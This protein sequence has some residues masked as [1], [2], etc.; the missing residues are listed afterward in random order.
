MKHI[1]TLCAVALCLFVHAFAWAGE[2]QIE[3][4]TAPSK[5]IKE[6]LGEHWFLSGEAKLFVEVSEGSNIVYRTKGQ[7]I[8]GEK[9]LYYFNEKFS[10]DANTLLLSVKVAR[11]EGNE[12]AFHA[13]VG[14]GG[15]AAA[16]AAVGATI[17]GVATGGLLA[18]AGA[19][20]GALIGAVV[21]AA[22]GAIAPL[23]DA[24]TV[25]SYLLPKNEIVGNHVTPCPSTSILSDGQ[26]MT[27]II[28]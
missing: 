22:G 3:T 8:S 13:C 10:S 12:R 4:F 25:T 2:Y 15:G 1:V 6:A 14:A 16:G 7:A 21:G 17:T 27:L 5:Y 28:K 20:I 19:A 18:P 9:D 11:K 26:E 23:N 24:A